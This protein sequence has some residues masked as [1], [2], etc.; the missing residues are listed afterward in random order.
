MTLYSVEGVSSQGNETVIYVPAIAVV[1]APTVAELTGASALN[2]GYALRGFSPASEQGTSED[3][4]LASTQTFEN[5]GRVRK[6]IDDITYVYD[7][8]AAAGVASNKHYQ[9]LKLGVK[10]FLV[11]RRGIPATTAVIAGQFVDI[12]PVQFGDQ[13]RVAV[14]PSAEGGKFEIIQKPFVTGLVVPDVAVV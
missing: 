4:R 1:T 10:G 2:L 8:Q 7:P 12:I 14:D 5:P 3:I 11:D 13:R 9:A 6:T